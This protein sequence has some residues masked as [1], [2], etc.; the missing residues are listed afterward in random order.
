[1]L[2]ETEIWEHIW[3]CESVHKGVANIL[4]YVQR[5]QKLFF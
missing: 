5:Q 3:F 4:K 2:F 1:M